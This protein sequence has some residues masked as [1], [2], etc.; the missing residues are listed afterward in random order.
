MSKTVDIRFEIL[1]ILVTKSALH[2]GSKIAKRAATFEMGGSLNKHGFG[3]GKNT[4][5]RKGSKESKYKKLKSRSDFLIKL[6][7][8]SRSKF[9]LKQVP[10]NE[11]PRDYLK[12]EYDVTDRDIEISINYFEKRTNAELIETPNKYMTFRLFKDNRYE[13]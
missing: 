13:L 4:S 3:R 7:F 11:N 10:V 12:R 6:L 5:H 2:G 8:M 1:S 9:K